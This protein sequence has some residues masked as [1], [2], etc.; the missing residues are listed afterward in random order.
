MNW[1]ALS[2][3]AVLK[4]LDVNPESGLSSNNIKSRQEK[5]GPNIFSEGKKVSLLKVFLKQFKSPLIYLLLLAAV[6]A[7]VMDERKDSIVIIVVVLFNSLIGTIQ[8]GKAER[9]L[10][11][12]KKV[13]KI[14][15]RVLRD[16]QEKMI[17]AEQLVPGDIVSFLPGDAITADARIIDAFS[18][19]ASE[20][21]LT[22]ESVPVSKES[23]PLNENLHLAD[24]INMLYSGTF[25]T[26]GRAKAVVVA[27]GTHSEIG[28]IAEL[29]GTV[30][31][32][33]TSLETKVKS[34]SR[35]II[36]ASFLL[37]ILITSI[38]L[39]QGISLREILLLAI[40]QVVSIIPEGLPVAITVAAVVGVQRM[41]Q[42]KTIVRRLSAVEAL[43]ATTIICSDKTGTLTRN[44][45]V[46][47]EFRLYP[48]LTIPWEESPASD[49]ADLKKLILIS[50]LCN[51]AQ[52]NQEE[53]IGDPTETSLVSAAQKIGIDKKGSD[54]MYPRID[55]VPFDSS[56]K[57]MATLHQNEKEGKFIALK[58]SPDEIIHLCGMFYHAGK[59]HPLNDEKKIEIKKMNEDMA[60][61]ALRVLAFA[62]VPD[63][64][65]PK[66]LGHLS[67]QAIFLGLAGQMD[68]P[69][70]EVKQAISDCLRAGIRPIMITGDHKITG[71][72]IA[73]MIGLAKKNDIAIEGQEIE[74]TPLD[75]M[76]KKIT[77]VAVFARV[78]PSQKLK[79][80]DYFQKEGEVVAMTGDGVN[81]APALSKADVGVAMGITGTEVAKS[82]SKIIITDDNF[83][84]IVVAIAQGR[85]V[86]QNIRKVILLLFST[87]LS[88]VIVLFVALISGFAAP[89]YAVQIL[90]NNLVTDG[91][92]TVNLIMEPEEGNELSRAPV[93]KK[94][95]LINSIMF[96][97]M[98][99]IVPSIAISTFGW[100]TWRIAQGIDLDLV[101]TETLTVL[102][103]CEWFNA[104]NCRSETK[105][106]LSW[107]ILKNKW[108]LGALSVS[109]I[110]HFL[111]VF[112]RPLGKHFYTV[113]IDLNT[114]PLLIF[115]GSLVLWVE[116]I[117]KVVI[118][119]KGFTSRS[120]KLLLKHT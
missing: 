112:W 8:E 80:V 45:M 102:I 13:T 103:I 20:A 88:E 110:L 85:L 30:K 101:R 74:E 22:G 68:P 40:G 35:H 25:V 90:W 23:R 76:R 59:A 50:I 29:T 21:V 28:K 19:K 98:L 34:F 43:G 62:Y 89:Y 10:A 100:F 119:K 115:I 113:P 92:I 104:L 38:G 36:Y 6:I 70:M 54:E 117:R 71:L 9:S 67:G 3:E 57:M 52:L 106:A 55:E 107:D 53:V 69:R 111:L 47:S 94:E 83:S 39:Y 109:C 48:S 118:R 42:R 63:S 96:K 97:R 91:V 4:E 65:L 49:N 87:S 16:G 77:R 15:V 1:H 60:S 120:E 93:S 56:I 105:S 12:L 72:A 86:Y 108:L 81:D 17:P 73:R 58:G 37:F 14:S 82:A 78:H 27:T 51:D 5:Y 11:A 66:N 61:S 31:E 79:I 84:T 44:E 24:R 64:E 41:A 18:L 32:S 46:V 26:N 95:P 116:E 99:L 114:L 33:L 7:F 2:Q 75:E